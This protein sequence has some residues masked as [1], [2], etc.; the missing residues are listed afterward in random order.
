VNVWLV[1]TGWTGGP[2]G[3]GKRMPIADTRALIR[4]ALDGTLAEIPTE[5]EPYF[6]LNIPT[7][8]PGVDANLLDAANT[9]PNVAD[10][11]VQARKLAQMFADNF[12]AF[13]DQV[14]A[15]VLA[16]GPTLEPAL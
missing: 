14:S 16:A 12:A 9:W 15:T 7:S 6:G 8:C 2:Y 13:A 3:I 1:N 5:V 4:A 11:D 10:Y